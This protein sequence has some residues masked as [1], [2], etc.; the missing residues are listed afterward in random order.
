MFFFKLWSERVK[1]QC[2]VPESIHTPSPRE[3]LE[4]SEGCKCPEAR[5]FPLGVEFPRRG[6]LQGF[7]SKGVTEKIP[8]IAHHCLYP[9]WWV[10]VR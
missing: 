1:I 5:F 4:S 3:G 7:I 10:S 6:S 2:A 8:T 9:E